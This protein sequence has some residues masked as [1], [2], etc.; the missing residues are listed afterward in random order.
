MKLV[1][2]S[3][4]IPLHE[5]DRVLTAPGT[6]AEI[7]LE[8]IAGRP[9]RIWKNAPRTFSELLA[10]ASKFG[11]ATFLVQDTHR[12]SYDAFSRAVQK[13]AGDLKASG[14]KSGD[15]VAI[16][17]RNLPEWPVVFFA[18]VSIGAIAVPLNAWWTARELT[19]ALKDSASILLFVDD[20]RWHV[21]KDEVILSGLD[22]VFVCRAKEA[23][24]GAI[25]LE[26]LIGS[27]DNW[28]LL[29]PYLGGFDTSGPEDPAT[30]LYTSGTS[31]LPKGAIGTHRNL[32]TCIFSMRYLAL[33]AASRA[34]IEPAPASPK[35]LLLVIPLFHVTGLAANLL[36][37]MWIG[38]KVVLM[39]RWNAKDALALIKAE[40]VTVTGGVPTIPVQLLSETASGDVDISSLEVLTYGGAPAPPTL[41]S[42]IAALGHCVPG[43]GW[44]M[45]ETSAT[46]TGHFGDDYVQRPESAGPPVPV[47]ELRIVGDNGDLPPGEVGELWVRGPQVVQGYWNK[48]K[49]TTETFVDG[50]V[51]TGDLCRIDSEGFLYVV[52]RAK[53][54]IIRGGENIYSVEVESALLRHPEVIEAAV[55]GVPHPTLGEVPVAVVQLRQDQELDEAALRAWV[56]GELARFKVPTAIAVQSAALPRNENGKILKK[57]I[58]EQW[59]LEKAVPAETGSG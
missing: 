16:A 13:L 3:H 25:S 22:R 54:V 10:H 57:V 47:A 2:D 52:D 23:H 28:A 48:P 1:G 58:R 40:R 33:R 37:H 15:R 30:I 18:V 38:S 29:P 7:V 44:G 24:K 5:V 27:P 43:N 17:M 4:K 32:L 51:K 8:N 14:L 55:F 42:Q 12:I 56:A 53:D 19:H 11:Q 49:E 21:L 9:V 20:E 6:E 31:G 59:I 26:S 46:V 35:V 50:W 45:T 39:G 34:G 41:A 36:P